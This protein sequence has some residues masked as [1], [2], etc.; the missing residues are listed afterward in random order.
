MDSSIE[1]RPRS[2]SLNDIGSPY[3]NLPG[4]GRRPRKWYLH[5]RQSRGGIYSPPFQHG[6]PDGFVAQP[7]AVG[8]TGCRTCVGVCFPVKDST[9]FAAHIDGHVEAEIPEHGSSVASRSSSPPPDPP[10][11]SDDKEMAE[12]LPSTAQGEKLRDSVLQRLQAMFPEIYNDGYPAKLKDQVILLCPRTMHKGQRTT[13]SWIAEAFN[14]FLGLS[15]TREDLRQ[16]HGFLIDFSTKPPARHILGFRDESEYILSGGVHI[17]KSPE[18]SINEV[19]QENWALMNR[20]PWYYDCNN[21]Y[22]TSN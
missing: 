3:L 16:G 1:D 8:T 22:W 17:P 2:R 20:L 5:I 18:L 11:G 19:T 21:G 10:L 12:W 6:S 4:L 14:T 7:V 9:C 13:G 15:R